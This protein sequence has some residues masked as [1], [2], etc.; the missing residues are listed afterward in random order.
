MPTKSASN[1][2]YEQKALC[3]MWGLGYCPVQRCGEEQKQILNPHMGGTPIIKKL[4]P[5]KDGQ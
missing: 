1:P 5:L 4:H 2:N 3:I